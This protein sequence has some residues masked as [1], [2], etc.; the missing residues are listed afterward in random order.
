M[1]I[2]NVS[3]L[4]GVQG[5]V[6]LFLITKVCLLTLNIGLMTNAL[7]TLFS[8]SLDHNVKVITEEYD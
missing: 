5:G 2:H 6:F 3:C 1:L 8:L 4:L 7:R